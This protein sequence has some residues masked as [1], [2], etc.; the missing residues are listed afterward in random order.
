MRTP[1]P[2]EMTVPNNPDL[3]QAAEVMQSMLRETGFDLRLNAMEFASSLQAATRGDFETYLLAWSGRADPD[4][5]TWT[6]IHSQGPQNDGKY[7]NPEVDRLLGAARVETNAA[8]RVALYEQM[9]QISLRQDR[10][11]MYLWHRKNIV[12][13]SARVTGF[14]AVP[15]GLIRMQDLR[16]N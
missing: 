15:D 16:L 11:R 14:R 2:V 8:R 12:G 5:N 13:H 7:S 4:G 3:R 1:L 10:H 6:F 9:W